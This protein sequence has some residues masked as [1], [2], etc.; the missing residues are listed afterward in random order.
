M[1]KDGNIDFQALRDALKVAKSET[2]KPSLIRV[3][4]TIGFGCPNKAGSEKIHGAPA[5]PAEVAAM[6]EHLGW[7]LGEFQVPE[8]VYDV[9]QS[10]SQQGTEKEQQWWA[11]FAKYKDCN[12]DNGSLFERAVLEKR[13]PENWESCLPVVQEQDKAL[14]S[15]QHSQSCLNA[16]CSVLPELIG[17][18]A[19]LAPSNLTLMK[20]AK[21]FTPQSFEG[22]NMRFGVREFGMAAI[23]NAMSLHGSGL[24]PYCATFTVSTDYMRGAIRL[25]ALA[26]AGSI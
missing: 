9:F 24:V 16:M 19:D 20:A 17:G 11:M 12:P 14:A 4:T 5:G 26:R 3:K 7:E 6:R 25:A 1:G 8:S 2:T 22:R 13:L 15:R 18:S 23:C 21:D 10:H